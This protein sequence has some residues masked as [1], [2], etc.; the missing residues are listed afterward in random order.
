[1]NF[2]ALRGPAGLVR[3]YVHAGPRLAPAA[4]LAGLRAGRTFVTN[5]PLLW[6]TV[7]GHEPGDVVRPAG[8]AATA[9]VR[10]ISN[11]PLDHVEV[12][13]NGRVVATV[14]LRDGG[15]RAE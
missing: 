12:I 14:P 13:G 6:F 10:V 5:A 4:F 2:A 7:D 1:P 9:R 3:A 8:G 15:T 11:V